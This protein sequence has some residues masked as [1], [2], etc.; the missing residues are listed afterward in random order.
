[1]KASISRRHFV[2]LGLSMAG[3]ALLASC[4]QSSSQSPSQPTSQQTK[5][6]ASGNAAPTVASNNNKAAPAAQASSSGAAGSIRW[7]FRGSADELKGA[8]KFLQDTFG[9]DHP[10]IKVSVEPAP[11]SRDE[12]LIAAMVGGNA[13]DVFETWGD[14]VTQFADRGQVTDVDPLVK[15]DYKADDLK[16]FYEWQWRDFVLPSRIR[17]GLPKYVNVMFI[18]YNKDIFDKAGV[19]PPD[20]TWTHQTYA[21]TAIKLTQKKGDAVDTWGLYYPVWSWDRFWYKIDAWGGHVVDPNDNTHAILDSS[22]AQQAFE[23]SRKLMWDD[24]AMAQR[25]LLAGS[26]QSYNTQDL[27]ATGKFAMVED[28]F[29]PFSMAKTIQK[30]VNWAYAHTPPGPKERKVLGTTDGFSMWKG[31]K[32]ADASWE[33]LKFLAGKD[34]QINQCKVTGLLP[35]RFSALAEWKKICTSAY[36]ELDAV[37]L[38]VGPKAM[39]MG[40]PGNRQFFKKDAEARQILTPA[41]EK[42]F[43]SGGTPVSYFKDISKQITDKMRS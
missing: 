22:E 24:K 31:S 5:A 2:A 37:N 12:K 11:D 14:N 26:G 29:Y 10:N 20:D 23:W 41:L 4:A 36:P 19:K 6:S 25:L 1:M 40:Y 34:Y 16:D 28:G 13:P 33:L 42:V 27:F 30:K 7:Q 35:V 21:E 15:R 17:F 38:D 3:G 8:N 18:W 43:I 39:E 32:S 9:K